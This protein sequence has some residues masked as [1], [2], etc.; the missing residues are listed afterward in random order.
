MTQNISSI[1][2]ESWACPRIPNFFF[3]W[4][5]PSER[6]ERELF[7]TEL[8]MSN[9]KMGFGRWLMS[10]LQLMRSARPKAMLDMSIQPFPALMDIVLVADVSMDVKAFFVGILCI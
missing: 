6:F 1:I 5:F 10:E 7:V 9:L 8:L 4:Y 3:I 2:Y